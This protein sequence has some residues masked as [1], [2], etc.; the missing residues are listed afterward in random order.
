M[1]E[2]TKQKL[3]E[4]KRSFRGMM[5]GVASQSMRNKGVSYK[6]NWGVPLMELRELATE[7]GKDYDLALALWDEDIRECKI[8][9]GLIMPKENMTPELASKWMD[10]TP[11]QEIAELTTF[12]LYQYIGGAKELAFSW[13]KRPDAIHR[14]AAFHLLLGLFSKGYHPTD[15]EVSSV[16]EQANLVLSERQLS[17]KHAAMNCL[18]SL[19]TLDDKYA[20]IVKSKIKSNDLYIF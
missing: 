13:I 3:Q 16:V 2:D 17:V 5:N 4:V 7:Y 8:L 11:T 10:E 6:L 20:Q 1:R 19:V 9:A 18:D 14:I 15:Q 12:H